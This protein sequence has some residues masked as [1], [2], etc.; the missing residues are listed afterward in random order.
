MRST[1]S[2][3]KKLLAG[4]FTATLLGAAAMAAPIAVADEV[5][6][7]GDA[8]IGIVVDVPAAG[9]LSMT[10]D[11]T[12]PVV[13]AETTSAD[14]DNRAFTGTLPTVTV[15]DTRTDIEPGVGWSVVGQSSDFVHVDDP[16]VTIGGD[17]LGWTP[18][19]VDEP[20]NNESVA[21]GEV[22]ESAAE[23]GDGLAVG[24]DFLIWSFDS[25]ESQDTSEEHKANAE[26]RL[27]APAADLVSG[28]YEATL[29]LSLF[30]F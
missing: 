19:L 5:E 4:G 26:L 28:Q 18:E 15:T 3:T 8:G 30:E 24:T 11:T 12:T 7:G 20:A 10:V 2:A 23:G 9:A 13:L 29:T 21:P 25:Q 16:A 22:V 27:V 14:P 17:N 1:G 6:L